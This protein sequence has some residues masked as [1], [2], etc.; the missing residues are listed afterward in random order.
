MLVRAVKGID[1][2]CMNHGFTGDYPINHPPEPFPSN[3]YETKS[4]SNHFQP[5]ITPTNDN[6]S[7]PWNL[8]IDQIHLRNS[9]MNFFS[10]TS[11]PPTDDCPKNDILLEG[12]LDSIRKPPSFN[13][14]IDDGFLDMS[15]MQ[16]SIGIVTSNIHPSL[17]KYSVT[18]ELGHDKDSIKQE[19]GRGDSIYGCSNQMEDDDGHK[20]VRRS[21]RQQQSK[22][23]HAK[24]R[25]RKK[26]NDRLYILRSLV[27]KITKVFVVITCFSLDPKC[28]KFSIVSQS[29]YTFISFHIRLSADG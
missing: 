9:P 10:G 5:W 4:K 29:R 14:A 18:K 15:A 26:L 28:G 25:R 3:V 24:R 11:L 17:A 13:P 7:L 20:A 16:R 27:P 21:G 19:M 8:S 2:P 1:R 12:T 22:N 23:L 6:S